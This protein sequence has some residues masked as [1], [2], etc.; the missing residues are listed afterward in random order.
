[1]KTLVLLRHSKSEEPY[2][3]QKDVEREL[4]GT[5]ISDAIFR[6]QTLKDKKINFDLFLSSSAKRTIQTAH[7]VAEQVG[8]TIRN[9]QLRDELYLASTRVM[10][11]EINTIDDKFETVL[12]IAH[13]PGTSYIAEYLCGENIGN[14][15]TSGAA[16]IEFETDSWQELSQHTGK[17]L[18]TDFSKS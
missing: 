17:L 4:N 12:L 7:L 16:C 6:G 13:N 9:I 15:N 18:W 8:Y 10:L 11:E 14:F 5:G 3:R 2:V 1:M